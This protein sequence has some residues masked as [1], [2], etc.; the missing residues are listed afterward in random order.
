MSAQLGVDLGATWLRLCLA[1]NGRKKWTL[2]LPAVDWRQLP[3]A[4][5]R[6]LRSKNNPELS[7][8]IVGSTR[9]GRPSDRS[10]LRKCLLALATNVKVY[11]DFEIAHKASFRNGP[12]V[13][14]VASTGSVAFAR[15]LRQRS[16]RTGGAGPL[17]GD[18]GSGFWLGREGVR[19]E[20]LRRRLHLPHPLRL[21][22]YANPVRATAALAAKVLRGSPQL[23]QAAAQHLSDLAKGASAGLAL[24]HPIPVTL[25]GS[26]FAHA[27][28]KK[29]VLR[30]L[31][32]QW[33]EVPPRVSAET[34]AAGL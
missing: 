13:V 8:I 22:H 10:A 18:E 34:A 28:L 30:L 15:D 26:L 17:F 16:Q 3:E 25:H 23:C 14:L 5:S 20:Q 29:A 19:N 4:L 1:D 9:I 21:A 6:V 27:P 24:P 32:P 2:R 31:G 11:P 7:L 12:G 33:K